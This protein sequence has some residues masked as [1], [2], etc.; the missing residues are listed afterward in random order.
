MGK[1]KQSQRE[2]FANF[3]LKGMPV[4]TY[5]RGR[6]REARRLRLRPGLRGRRLHGLRG[7]LVAAEPV[8]APG[9]RLEPLAHLRLHRHHRARTGRAVKKNK[10][11]T[12]VRPLG[13]DFLRKPCLIPQL[14]ERVLL[15][16]PSLLL[17]LLLLTSSLMMIIIIQVYTIDQI[18]MPPFMN[19]IIRNNV[20]LPFLVPLEL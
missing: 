14:P 9:R 11:P 5:A 17:L 16:P 18:S 7:F 8:Q 19:I 15:L 6:R 1:K 13:L 20:S 10:S 4:F 3:F 2:T 12:K